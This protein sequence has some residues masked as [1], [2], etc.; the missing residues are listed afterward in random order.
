MAHVSGLPLQDSADI[1]NTMFLRLRNP[2]NR[3][4]FQ[5]L[6]PLCTP[7]FVYSDS[8]HFEWVRW[9]VPPDVAREIWGGNMGCADCGRNHIRETDRGL[10]FDTA[11]CEVDWWFHERN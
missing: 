11:W 5:A 1:P 2:R 4:D 6:L 7:L 8:D 10:E 3:G 9:L